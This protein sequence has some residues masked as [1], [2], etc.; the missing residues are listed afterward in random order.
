VSCDKDF[1]TIKRKLRKSDRVYTP[2]EYVSLI[3]SS[4][5]LQRFSVTMVECDDIINFKSWWR[6]HLKKNSVS[7]ETLGRSVPK[8][9][10]VNLQISQLNHFTYK[11]EN[12]GVVKAKPFI[13]GIKTHTFRLLTA[14]QIPP[15][16][17]RAYPDG[18]LPINVNNI[19]DV[20]NF[21]DYIPDDSE[22]QE[23]YQQIFS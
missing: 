6:E 18:R 12:V 3:I 10:K 23:F 21:K 17:V 15:N 13:G 16:P 7:L 9:K 2:K 20:R 8:D 19:K 14:A 5:K 22:V 1:G 4:T 11:K